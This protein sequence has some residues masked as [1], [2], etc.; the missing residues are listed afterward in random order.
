[1]SVAVASCSSHEAPDSLNNTVELERQQKVYRE[2]RF[3][4]KQASREA[5]EAYPKTGTPEGGAG[6]FR[7]MQDSLRSAYWNAVCD[8]NRIDII[9]SDS[10]WTKGVKEK[11]SAVDR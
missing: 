10:I 6:E 3:A 1:M 5:L 7:K 11:W 4:V 2:L 9:Y 8:S